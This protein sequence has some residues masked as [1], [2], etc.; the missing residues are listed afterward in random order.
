MKAIAGKF[1]PVI[2]TPFDLKAGESYV[3][4]CKKFSVPC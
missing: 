4:A 2:V 1:V 3:D